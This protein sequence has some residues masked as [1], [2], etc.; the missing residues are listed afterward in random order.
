MG[1]APSKN[2]D[3]MTLTFVLSMTTTPWRLTEALQARLLRLLDALP[4]NFSITLNIPKHLKRDNEAPY[5]AVPSGLRNHPRI[6][7]SIVPD[8]G[9]ITKVF[10]TL[11]ELAA[12]GSASSRT[13]VIALDD[14]VVYSP[15]YI[16]ALASAFKP[17][18]LTAVVANLSHAS[19]AKGLHVP[20]S[21]TGYG[22]PV[23]LATRAFL[24]DLEIMGT[25]HGTPCY[26]S[27]NFVFGKVITKNGIGT[28][29]FSTD[30]VP[31]LDMR[32]SASD[33]RGLQRQNHAIMY[34]SCQDHMSFHHA[35][36]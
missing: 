4:K 28:R 27:D 11:K 9:P 18:D 36:Q 35:W 24:S 6:K 7:A 31:D 21:A 15:E 13:V 22:V 29:G 14:D 26:T 34:Q 12:A 10:P 32:Q 20:Q 17:N 19:Y 33:P 2:T 23:A 1:Q 30:G 5:P 8:Y 25:Q 16:L 3:Y